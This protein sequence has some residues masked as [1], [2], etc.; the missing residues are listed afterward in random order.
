MTIIDR[1]KLRMLSD[2]S[3]R[4]DPAC[5][6]LYIRLLSDRDLMMQGGGQFLTVF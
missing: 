3:A 2:P 6:D 1:E 5:I 4:L